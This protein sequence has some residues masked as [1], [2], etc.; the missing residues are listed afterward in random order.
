MGCDIRLHTEVKIDG[1][2]YTYGAPHMERNYALFARWLEFVMR[3]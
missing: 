2:W 1:T 3:A